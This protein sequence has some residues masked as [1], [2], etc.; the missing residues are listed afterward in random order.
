LDFWGPPGSTAPKGE[1]TALGCRSTIV[2]NLT[3]IGVT[4]ARY[5]KFQAKNTDTAD[6]ISDKMYTSAAFVG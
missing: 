1:K 5:N 2:Q 3:P 6:L 4:V